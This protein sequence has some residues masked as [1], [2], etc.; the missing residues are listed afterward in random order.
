M[1]GNPP[2]QSPSLSGYPHCDREVKKLASKVWPS[3]EIPAEVTAV[4]RGRGTIWWGG[5]L[6]PVEGELYPH[7]EATTALLKARKVNEDFRSDGPVRY[8]HRKLAHADIW[9]V[10]N[11]TDKPLVAFCTFRDVTGAP[12]CWDPMTGEIRE[13][14]EIEL[15][16]PDAVIPFVFEPYQSFFVVFDHNKAVKP[17]SALRNFYLAEVIQTLEGPWEV[18]FDPQWGGP[19]EITF[20]KLTDWSQNTIKGIR[21]YSGIAVYRKTFTFGSTG[22]DKRFYLHLGKVKNM[23]RV[24]INGKEA[25]IVWTAPW[26]TDVTSLLKEGENLLEI[27]VAN[28][29]APFPPFRS[30]VR[31]L[32]CWNQDSW[33][34]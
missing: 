17:A 4:K 16:N 7:Y 19:E 12:E 10:A 33:D 20:D 8:T 9:F 21:Y 22:P 14:P 5:A 23:A 3:A 1:T 29:W 28:L 30:I 15:L 24:R 31:I 25:G 13:L 32:R 11:K 27:D 26:Q 18:S 2:L 6:N 34:L